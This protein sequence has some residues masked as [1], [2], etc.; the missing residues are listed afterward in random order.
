MI[1]CHCA[2]VT[3]REI[4]QLVEEGATTLGEITRRCGAGRHCGPCR[5]ELKGLLSAACPGECLVE[6]AA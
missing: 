2:G 3:D 5:D 1:V 6:A 4:V